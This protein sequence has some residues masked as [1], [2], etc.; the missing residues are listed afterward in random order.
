MEVG[1]SGLDAPRRRVVKLLVAATIL[2]A[3][4][5]WAATVASSGAATGAR[6]AISS[7]SRSAHAARPVEQSPPAISGSTQ[8]GAQLSASPGTWSPNP[9][10]YAYKWARCNAG[11]S[12]CRKVRGANSST[13]LLR[14]RDA[15]SRLRVSVIAFAQGRRSRPANS[16]LTEVVASAPGGSASHLEYVLDDGTAHVYSI[17]RGF[18]EVESFTIPE[19]TRGV[20][21]VEVCPAKATMYFAVGGDGGTNGSGSVVA[22]SL[23]SHKKLW[24]RNY[25]TGI[26]SM[27][28]TPDCSKLYMPVGELASS[29]EWKILSTLDGSEQGAILTPGTG[30]HDGVLSA[31]G[32][33]LLLGDRNYNHLAVY[34]NTTGKLQEQVGPLFGGVRPLTID[35]TDKLTFTTATGLAGFQVG[36]LLGSAPALW[37]ENFGGTCSF[38]TCSHGISLTP[39]SKEVAVIDAAHKAVQFW[40]VEGAGAGKAPTHVATVSVAGLSGEESGC[41]YDCARDGWV[42]HSYDGRYVFVGDS[43]DV[44]S[45]ATHKVVAHLASMENT[46][47]TIEVDWENGSPI[48]TT[49]R[50]G[51]G[52]AG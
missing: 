35:G 15:G 46:R 50:T 31:D 4:A 51:V 48:A 22:Y 14:A 21:G 9:T 34:N 39:D 16:A 27:A 17:D 26:D 25:S 32:K 40:N 45:T 49:Q 30:P 13:Y 52:R 18:K 38:T 29:G 47:K 1:M 33:I 24:Q 10:S 3:L 43:G 12:G 5:G 23:I 8:V 44:I 28:I 2:V 37:T 6:K 20:R 7:R 19:G 36:S 41:A 42:Q 11:G